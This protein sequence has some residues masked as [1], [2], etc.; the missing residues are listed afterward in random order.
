MSKRISANT[1]AWCDEPI[2]EDYEFCSDGCALDWTLQF[3][4]NAELLGVDNLE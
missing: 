2:P 1:C 3:P 4:V